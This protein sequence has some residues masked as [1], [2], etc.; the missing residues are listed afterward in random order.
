MHTSYL[1][2]DNQ[3]HEDHLK[4]SNYIEF[5]MNDNTNQ[6]MIKVQ[7]KCIILNVWHRVASVKMM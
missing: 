7:S 3:T 1:N 6:A 4:R 2:F 5:D